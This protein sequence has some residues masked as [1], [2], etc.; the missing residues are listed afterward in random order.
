MPLFKGQ[1]VL[2]AGPLGYRDP[3]L[4]RRFWTI[5][6]RYRIASMSAVPTVYAALTRHPVDAD[7][8]SLRLPIVGA[9]PLPAA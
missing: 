1:H 2:W 7:I 5:V 8:S 3:D 9:S 6:E 4:F